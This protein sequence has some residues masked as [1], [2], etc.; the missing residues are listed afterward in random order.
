MET[1]TEDPAS[2]PATLPGPLPHELEVL[3]RVALFSALDADTLRNL[4]AGGQTVR[5]PRGAHLFT[6][7]GEAKALHVL[8]EGQVGLVGAADG[9]ETV[10]EI[11]DAGEAFI[12]A[13]VL[14][15]QPY[16][17]GA[18]ALTQCRT[19]ELPRENL[20]TEL[21]DNP[22]L[23]LAMLGSL[24]K[25]YRQLVR[26]VKSLK[27]KSAGQRLAVYLMG[28]TP[29]RRGSVILRLPHNKG[30]IAQ[31]VGVRPETLS[32]VFASL[33]D[34]GVAMDGHTV[35]ILDLA[36]LGQFCNGDEEPC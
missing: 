19:L 21:L 2:R 23:A 33:R 6:Q 12:I 16:L 7:G 28:L 30:V 13:A 9:V 10:V 11:L 26:E 8:L 27:L 34:E 18:V 20:L 36:K 25:H 15:G 3:G 24:A 4:V 35:A 1:L 29:K 31:R 17:T 32:R 5:H 14:T 22:D